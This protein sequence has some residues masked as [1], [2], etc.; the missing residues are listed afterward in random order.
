MITSRRSQP[1]VDSNHSADV[2][3]LT[4]TPWDWR[5]FSA[6]TLEFGHLRPQVEQTRAQYLEYRFDLALVMNGTRFGHA[7][8]SN[9]GHVRSPV[10]VSRCRS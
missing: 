10:A 9:I 4:M 1:T 8:H 6:A 7:V 5:E 3:E 2:P